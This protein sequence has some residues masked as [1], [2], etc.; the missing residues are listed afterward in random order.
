MPN[1]GISSVAFALC[2]L[3]ITKDPWALLII[4]RASEKLQTLLANNNYL[5]A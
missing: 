4:T 3:P 5:K 1:N 2:I